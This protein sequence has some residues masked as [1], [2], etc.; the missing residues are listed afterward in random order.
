MNKMEIIEE[1]DLFDELWDATQKA[2]RNQP[3]KIPE[4]HLLEM[5]YSL[6][7]GTPMA[8]LANISFFKENHSL[9]D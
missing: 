1:F 7:Q 6:V 3:V 2:Y 8:G 4:T 9:S 5:I